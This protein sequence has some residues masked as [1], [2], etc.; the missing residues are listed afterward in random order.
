MAKRPVRLCAADVSE[1]IREQLRNPKG[2]VTD[3]RVP[4]MTDEQR[5]DHRDAMAAIAVAFADK[6]G[7][8][9]PDFMRAMFMCD[10][11]LANYSLY[12]G[13]QGASLEESKQII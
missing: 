13:E 12:L 2:S 10:C 7:D 1:I 8:K 11:G 5:S 6:F 9:N 3:S 4:F